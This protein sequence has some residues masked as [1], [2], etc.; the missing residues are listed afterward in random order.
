MSYYSELD[1]FLGIE[2]ELAIED[3]LKRA[4]MHMRMKAQMKARYKQNKEAEVG[5]TIQCACCNKS[6]VKKQYAQ[7][8]C[9]PKKKNGKKVSKCKD[10]YWNYTDDK[11]NERAQ[12]WS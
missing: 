8:F 12:R 4:E 7:C 3:A 2:E 1:D 10:R 11:R 9:S 5:A 6:I